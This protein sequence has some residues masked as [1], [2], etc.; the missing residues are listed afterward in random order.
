MFLLVEPMWILLY[1]FLTFVI[2]VVAFL[3]KRRLY[4]FIVEEKTEGER[5]HQTT[6]NHTR[7]KMLLFAFLMLIGFIMV[8]LFLAGFLSGSMW[9]ILVVS[10]TTGV[11][12]S[13]IILYILAHS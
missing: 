5:P 12:V 7:W 3:L 8:P 2:T 10:L 4:A 1:A 6:T 13:E 11:S 9:F